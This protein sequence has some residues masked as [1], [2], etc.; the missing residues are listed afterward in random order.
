MELQQ[1]TGAYIIQR[2]TEGTV[3]V[4]TGETLV[5]WD[6]VRWVSKPP[7]GRFKASIQ[8]LVPQANAGVLGG[9][10]EFC[11]HW[12]SPAYVGATL[13]WYLTEPLTHD[14][15]LLDLSIA[16]RAP[17]LQLTQRAQYPALL[18][19]LQQLDGAMVVDPDGAVAHLQGMLRPSDLARQVVPPLR[20]TRHTSA[21]RFSFDE[22]RS[23]VFVVSEDGPVSV[24]SDGART[25]LVRTDQSW[26]RPPGSIE[27][28]ISGHTT[29]DVAC[30]TCRKQLIVDLSVS[31]D[32]AGP[33]CP[34]CGDLILPGDE[35][36]AVVGIR[37]A[38]ALD[39]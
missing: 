3:R 21:R 20:G 39:C 6:G 30:G 9:I 15:R 5:T 16:Q 25:A 26:T 31:D 23:L 34:V 7:A 10:L 36:G 37:K 18:S 12:L 22:P 28:R 11:A 17:R 29:R 38:S 1:L 2:T 24:F 33:Y 27:Q 32:G 8:Q 35:S 19:V 14:P 13:V 4:F